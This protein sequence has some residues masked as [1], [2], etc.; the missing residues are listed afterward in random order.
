MDPVIAQYEISGDSVR[1]L[2]FRQQV[3]VVAADFNRL[4]AI[5]LRRQAPGHKQSETEREENSQFH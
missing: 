5:T 2:P 1:L 4:N 3:D